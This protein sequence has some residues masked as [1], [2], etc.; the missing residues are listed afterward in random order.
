MRYFLASILLAALVSNA[1]VIST[2]PTITP[3]ASCAATNAVTTNVTTVV[4]CRQVGDTYE[5]SVHITAT[6]A[7]DATN[8]VI[9]LPAGLV[10][11]TAKLPS[12]GTDDPGAAIVGHG[13]WRDAGTQFEPLSVLYLSTTT[14]G[15]TENSQRLAGN[16]LANT[17]TVKL[18]FAVPI[19]GK[20]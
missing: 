17:D 11:D 10:I 18:N 3:W 16:Q 7:G 6:G 5:F 19:V 2:N 1:Q 12:T 20:F 13:Q 14:V 8:V 9:T 4:R 15:V